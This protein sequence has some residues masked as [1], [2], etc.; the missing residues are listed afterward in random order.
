MIDL[1]GKVALVTGAGSGIGRAVASGLARRGA[2]VAVTDLSLPAATETAAA[3][4]ATG[5]RAQAFAADVADEEAVRTAIAKTLTA[6]GR[7]DIAVNNAGVPSS[8]QDLTRMS[9]EAWEAVL[10]VD[11]TG[12]FFSIKHEI[13]AMRRTGGGAIVNM[14]SGA[15]LFAIPRSPAY[16]A[17]KHGVIG[18]T[19]AAAMDHASAGIRVNAL[20]P[21]MTRTAKLE[22]VAEG[23]PMIAAHVTLTPLGRLGTP[24]EVADAAIWLCSDEASYVTGT[25]LT[26]DG[27]RRA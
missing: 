20:A 5:G 11:L 26:V 16:V 21:G 13:P 24:D 2:A 10:R 8:S 19:K 9:A 14:A 22:Q 17:S 7:L 6:F 4:Q 15:G 1:T 25:V 18:L 3:I 27:G 12:T 23:T